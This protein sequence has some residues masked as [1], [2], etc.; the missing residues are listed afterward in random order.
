MSDWLFCLESLF[1]WQ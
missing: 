1:L